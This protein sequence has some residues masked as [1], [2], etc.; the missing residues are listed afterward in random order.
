MEKSARLPKIYVC[1][2]RDM[3]GPEMLKIYG[4]WMEAFVNHT[5]DA[6][7]IHSVSSLCVTK[8]DN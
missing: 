2:V 6:S 4:V 7:H 5:E 1:D 8:P 3:T